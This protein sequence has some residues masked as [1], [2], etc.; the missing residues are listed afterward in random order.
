MQCQ[1]HSGCSES[2]CRMN[3]EML[4]LKRT[5]GNHG[6]QLKAPQFKTHRHT[7]LLSFDFPNYKKMKISFVLLLPACLIT[8]AVLWVRSLGRDK[9]KSH[10]VKLGTLL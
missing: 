1:T 8:H 5:L 10:S 3:R 6:G 4:R 7:G 2:A 9:A